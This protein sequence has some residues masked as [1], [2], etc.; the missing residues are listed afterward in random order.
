ME[1]AKRTMPL[2]LALP[3]AEDST[4]LILGLARALTSQ[5][6]TGTA[7]AGPGPGDAPEASGSS[8]CSEELERLVL[9]LV[10]DDRLLEGLREVG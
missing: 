8:G 7:A 9:E 5:S 4:T 2:S 3:A 6:S 1:R 10:A